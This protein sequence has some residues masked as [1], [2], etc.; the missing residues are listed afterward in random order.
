MGFS[1]LELMHIIIGKKDFIKLLIFLVH[2][3][4]YINVT[5]FRI[6]KFTNF[7]VKEEHLKNGG[8]RT[9]KNSH[10][11][12]EKACKNCE[13]QLFR[14]LRLTK[15]FQQ[16]EVLL[17]KKSLLSIGKNRKIGGILTCPI[18]IPLF[19]SDMVTFKTSSIV[20]IVVVKT[21]T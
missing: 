11:I 19:S 15:V 1:D 8:T 21:R 9:L 2:F 10:S 14:T 17:F 5:K 16:F 18:P 20:N 6:K 4:V 13:N 3:N 12:K 7:F